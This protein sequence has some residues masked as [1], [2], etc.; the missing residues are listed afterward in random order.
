MTRLYKITLCTQSAK[1]EKFHAEV[2]FNSNWRAGKNT[3]SLRTISIVTSLCVTGDTVLTRTN[4]K[5]P[6]LY[7]CHYSL[8]YGEVKSYG[9]AKQVHTKKNTLL[10]QI[11]LI[12]DCKSNNF[13][14]SLFFHLAITIC[15]YTGRWSITVMNTTRGR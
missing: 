5:V 6:M 11:I 4:T 10:I 8:N 15:V 14:W 12:Q 1:W 7:C 2:K 3:V 13:N 9:S